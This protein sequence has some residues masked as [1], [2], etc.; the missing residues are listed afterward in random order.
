M[1]KCGACSE[2]CVALDDGDRP[3]HTPC[4]HLRPNG[5]GCS[6]Y[7]ERP[8][9]CRLFVCKWLTDDGEPDDRP[10]RS[11]VLAHVALNPLA[12]TFGLN[13]IECRAGAFEQRA[14]LVQHYKQQPCCCVTLV[15]HDG[16]GIL[17][18]QD[19]RYIQLLR[20]T[21]G[22]TRLPQDIT[23]LEATIG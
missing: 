17:Y 12:E 3:A 14:D 8:P 10:D 21:N 19:T 16:T 13:V 23:M 15:K 11:G 6:R 22:W 20:E 18:S 4:Q 9:T 5:R 1:R 7:Y 2:C